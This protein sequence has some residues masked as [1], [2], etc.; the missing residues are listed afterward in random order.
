MSCKR[1]EILCP[2]CMKKK[3]MHSVINKEEE[4]WCDECGTEFILVDKN[5][6]KYK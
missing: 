4:T 3:L 1:I 2:N 6:V 5:T